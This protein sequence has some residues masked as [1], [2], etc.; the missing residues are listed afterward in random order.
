MTTKL[1]N[2]LIIG[3]GV[4]GGS[5]LKRM[6]AWDNTTIFA[7][8]IDETVCKK[9]QADNAN[10]HIIT[11]EDTE[12]FSTVDLVIVTLFPAAVIPTFDRL[13]HLLSPTTLVIDICGVKQQLCQQLALKHYHFQYILT[14]P[15]A[16]REAGGYDYSLSSLFQGANFLIISDV[17]Q[18]TP[19][20]QQALEQLVHQLGCHKIT[21]I[22]WAEHDQQITY[23]SQLSHILAVSLLNSPDFSEHTQDTIG[24]SFRDLTRIANMNIPLWHTLFLANQDQ[25]TTSIDHLIGELEQIK[26]AIQTHDDPT[27]RKLL[28][29]AKKRR[30]SFTTKET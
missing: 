17:M 29:S 19:S 24:D 7:L 20:M 5:F 30:I 1:Q 11:Y 23:V 2:I 14:H 27:L 18:A 16:G 8:D 26:T 3:L 22:P 9:A 21:Y 12:I 15:M 4:M 6:Q 28:S 13:E 10:L 25:L